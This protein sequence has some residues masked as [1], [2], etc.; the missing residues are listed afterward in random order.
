[1][2][3]HPHNCLSAQL[4][5]ACKTHNE[6]GDGQELILVLPPDREA[7]SRVGS[8]PEDG[9]RH[10]GGGSEGDHPVLTVARHNAADLAIGDQ[11]VPV[12][13][14]RAGSFAAG[15]GDHGFIVKGQTEF[16]DAQENNTSTG[17]ITANSTAAT[18]R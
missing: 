16:N 15:I 5:P 13:D 8:L 2:L 11:R 3:F 4:D 17:K 12:D 9:R 18:P 7:V 6:F 10:L 14:S 1:M